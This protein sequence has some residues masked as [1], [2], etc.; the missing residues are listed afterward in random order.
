MPISVKK[1]YF[2]HLALM[3]LAD[4]AALKGEFFFD[5]R[6]AEPLNL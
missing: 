6:W 5:V 1:L 3:F 2:Y 4:K